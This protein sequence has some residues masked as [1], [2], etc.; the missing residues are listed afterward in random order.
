MMDSPACG[1]HVPHLH[2]LQLACSMC[3]AVTFLRARRKMYMIIES[4]SPLTAARVAMAPACCLLHPGTD[5]LYVF[6]GAIQGTLAL[7][8]PWLAPLCDVLGMCL[9]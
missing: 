3:V 1:L 5:P 7:L 6:R 8:D 2:G 4:L 9:V